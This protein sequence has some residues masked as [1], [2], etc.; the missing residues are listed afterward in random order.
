MKRGFIGADPH[1]GGV[2]GLTPP[3]WQSSRPRYQA[4]QVDCWD[5]FCNEVTKYGNF[6]FAIWNG[7]MID[8]KQAKAGGRELITGDRN[9]QCEMAI[10]IIEK[11]N[12][13][14]NYL[15]YGTAYHVGTEEDFEKTIANAVGAIVKGHLFLD[16]NGRIFD[17]KHKVNTSIIPH[18]RYT[19]INRDALWN[20]LQSEIECQPR[21]DIF[22]RSH[23]HYFNYSGDADKLMIITPALRSL[24]DIYGTRECV[25][26]VHFGFLVFEIEDD[27]SYRWF[28]RI[29]KYNSIICDKPI[30]VGT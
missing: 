20:L 22:I 29:K 30:K 23:A 15:T 13:K 12:A 25:G 9:E 16:I 6:D 11:V 21:A 3:D 24:G 1:C 27:G 26:T 7:D 19:A 17:V 4:M 2:S 14:A 5:W 10:Q 8:G 28:W 18:G